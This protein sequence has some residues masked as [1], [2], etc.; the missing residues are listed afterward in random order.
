[1]QTNSPAIAA[2]REEGCTVRVWGFGDLPCCLG[3][4]GSFWRGRRTGGGGGRDEG[5]GWGC[6]GATRRAVVEAKV[7]GSWVVLATGASIGEERE[8]LVISV[9]VVEAV[10]RIDF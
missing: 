1:M 7:E 10:A 3:L 9:A 5:G 4:E 6:R 2:A 8:K